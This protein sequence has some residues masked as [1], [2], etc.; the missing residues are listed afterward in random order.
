MNELLDLFA[1]VRIDGIDAEDDGELDYDADEE[2]PFDDVFG[3]VAGRG[4][5]P[6]FG[7][8]PRV[9]AVD[10]RRPL[11]P[12][13]VLW[14]NGKITE[15]FFLEADYKGCETPLSRLRSVAE[16]FGDY[17]RRSGLFAAY[18]AA[19]DYLDGG[20]PLQAAAYA[21]V[22]LEAD[23]AGMLL[24]EPTPLP[25]PGEQFRPRS[26]VRRAAKRINDGADYPNGVI[27]RR[28]R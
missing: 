14:R 17:C 23:W 28:R 27:R 21:A 24:A 7:Y 1:D 19:S 16:A 9:L 3:P 8:P 25:G 13:L 12:R 4:P 6:W 10:L 22:A 20:T 2:Y 18:L 5:A 15:D 11:R 26:Y